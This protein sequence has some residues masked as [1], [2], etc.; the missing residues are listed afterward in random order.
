MPA[1]RGADASS[2]SPKRRLRRAGSALF[3]TAAL[4][5]TV[6]PAASAAPETHARNQADADVEVRLLSFGD[7]AETLRPLEGDAGTLVQS[8]GSRVDAGGAAYLAAFLD[9]L[10]RQSAN[11]LLFSAGG[12]V[13]YGGSGPFRMFGGEPTIEV[14]NAWDVAASAVG[15]PELSEGVSELLRKAQGGCHTDHGCQLND[16]FTGANFPLLGANLVDGEGEP[17]TLP[18]SIS[19]V[20]DVPI[21]AIGILT[22]DAGERASEAG[23]TADVAHIE[24][25]LDAISRTADVLEFFGVKAI[26]L[27]LYGDAG[28]RDDAGPNGCGLHGGPVYQL[29]QEASPKVDVV[30]SA[31]GSDSFNC[32]VRDPDGNERPLIRPASSGRTVSV[33]DVAINRATGEVLRERTSA[34]NQVVTRNVQPDQRTLEIIEHAEARAADVGDRKI[35]EISGAALKA[36]TPAGE[37]A[38]GR[39]LADASH[40]AA[41]HADSDAALLPPSALPDDLTDSVTYSDAFSAP[42]PAMLVTLTLTGAQLR[43]A[44]EQQFRDGDDVMLQPSAELTYAFVPE[45][46]GDARI[47]DLYIGGE[48][49][50]DDT[51]YRITVTDRIAIGGFGFPA[52]ADGVDRTPITTT[53]KALTDYL[54]THS[55]VSV[56]EE[57]RIS[58]REP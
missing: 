18:F 23:A 3:G 48:E 37:S 11:S 45:A 28:P 54:G 7:L 21:G 22:R 58:L 9:Q 12:N 43:E 50:R 40:A 5:T 47:T 42:R 19:Y 46:N 25:E 51:S 33:A 15:A 41:E 29:A 6:V 39:I 49:V 17:L 8:D 36:R 31:G 27:L 32:T 16:E 24:D 20:D 56:P 35:G 38:A 30:F 26:T 52:F 44:L 10:R 53:S 55:P 4:L 2:S 57:D 13:A 1:V 14:L 34:F